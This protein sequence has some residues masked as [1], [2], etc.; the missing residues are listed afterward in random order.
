MSYRFYYSSVKGT[1]HEKTNTPKQDNLSVQCCVVNDVE[2][3]ISSVA[4][5]AGTAKHSDISSNFICRFL[6]KRMIE[7]LQTNEISN[8]NQDVMYAWI[9][10]FQTIINRFIKIYK[11]SSI[12]DFA[13]TILFAALSNKGNIFVQIGDG[14]ISVGN[15]AELNCVFHPQK[16]EYANT[17]HFA[18][19]EKFE[20]NLMFKFVSENIERVAMHTDG[21]EMISL[22]NLETPSLAFFNPFFDC[23]VDEP[24]GYNEEL[25]QELSEFLNSERVNKRTNDDKTL[26]IITKLECDGKV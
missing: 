2:Y 19:E 25:S 13:T 16:G 23:L 20:N 1:S 11:L 24:N 10:K 21:I 9:R 4:D 17:T 14:A 26:V 15:S 5:G 8:F 7:W 3:L 22:V 12:R 6:N 18:T